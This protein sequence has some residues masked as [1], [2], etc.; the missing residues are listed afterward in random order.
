MAKTNIWIHEGGA[1]VR[2]LFAL[3]SRDNAVIR[4]EG[5]EPIRLPDDF[6]RH[7]N[8]KDFAA[9]LGTTS[10]NLNN[11]FPDP[12]KPRAEAAAC[13]QPAHRRGAQ[14]RAHLRLCAAGR[15]RRR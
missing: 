2:W 3:A 6:P 12:G 4:P 11:W 9:A 15:L 8:W 5:G 7:A 14:H 13:D 10:P 1:K